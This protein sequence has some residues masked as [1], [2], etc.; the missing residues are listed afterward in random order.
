M[1]IKAFS[2]TVAYAEENGREGLIN[3]INIMRRLNHPNII[4]LYEVHET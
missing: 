3:E 4:K 1:A 2:K